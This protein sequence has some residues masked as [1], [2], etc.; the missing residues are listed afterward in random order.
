MLWLPMYLY[1]VIF[2]VWLSHEP[3]STKTS[4]MLH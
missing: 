4:E 2:V 3:Y 1:S